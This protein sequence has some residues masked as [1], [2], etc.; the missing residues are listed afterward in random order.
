MEFLKLRLLGRRVSWL[1][2]LVLA[3]AL[4]QPTEAVAQT[5]NLISGMGLVVK[6]DRGGKLGQRARKIAALRATGE[7]VELR[8]TCLSACTM[9][10]DLPG[11]C[12]GPEAVFGFHGPTRDGRALPAQE[13]EHWSNLMASHYREPLRSW[14]MSEGRFRT[15]GYFQVSGTELIRMGYPA[16]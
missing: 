12:V 15:A 6:V 10:L 9:Y 4:A 2:G 14:Y 16:C 11:A 8:G 7:R 13:F 1:C 3:V 5:A